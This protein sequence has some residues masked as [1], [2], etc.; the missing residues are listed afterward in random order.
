MCVLPFAPTPISAAARPR[1]LH[2]KQPFRHAVA[3]VFDHLRH[4]AHQPIVD[5]VVR[6][7]RDRLTSFTSSSSGSAH[8]VDI[9]RRRC[10]EV[11]RDDCLD[12]RE[13]HAARE[14]IGANEQPNFAR[15]KGINGRR[16][17]RLR[18]ICGDEA[19]FDA[20]IVA[21]LKIQLLC[22]LLGLREDQDRGNDALWSR[23]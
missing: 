16:P 11:V 21:Q 17:L 18:S 14:Q 4:G 20:V 19:N 12:A 9:R 15:A 23:N 6:E 10:R 2:L 7:K 1:R 3:R 8:S 22:P 13:I 5:V